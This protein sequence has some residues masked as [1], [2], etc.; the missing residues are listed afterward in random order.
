MLR[1]RIRRFANERWA[2]SLTV[3]ERAGLAGGTRNHKVLR[4]LASDGV[5]GGA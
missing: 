3:D 4:R 1:R 5:E 2:S